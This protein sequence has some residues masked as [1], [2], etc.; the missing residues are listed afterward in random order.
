[1]PCPT[2]HEL[3]P[4]PPGK[5]GWP[6]TVESSLWLD[7]Q[8]TNRA[9]DATWPKFTIVTP[10]YN[11][12][13]YIEETIRSVLLQGYPN[14][15]YIVMDGGSQDGTVE[16]IR[17][18]APWLTYWCSE[19][20]RGQSQ[21]LNKGFA[22]ATGDWLAWL[23]ADDLYQPNALDQ[24]AAAARQHPNTHWIV[25]VLQWI[26]ETGAYVDAT[27]PTPIT[28]IWNAERWQ[29][30]HWIAQV[31]FR[32]SNL[33]RP[34]PTSFWSRTA[35]EA[36]GPLDEH[37]HY[38]MDLDR[39]GKVARRGYTPLLITAELASFRLHE[40]QKSATGEL[41]FMVDELAIVDTWLPQLSGNEYQILANYRSWLVEQMQ[42]HRQELRLQQRQHHWQALMRNPYYHAAFTLIKDSFHSTSLSR[43]LLR[44]L[45][46]R[47]PAWMFFYG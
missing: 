9:P 5:S 44:Q 10:A 22:R 45:N 15:E 43:M 16:I 11:S 36:V 2:C 24:V 21:A 35:H 47:R 3:P 14:L 46:K 33:F 41:P 19:P 25:G 7:Q 42:T 1:M 23:N 26:D 40:A 12:A 17:R 4:P 32:G 30:I 27:A 18:Y 31:C 13:T 20:D 38:A 37:L 29:G 34:Q 28:D 6:W 8:S 39:W